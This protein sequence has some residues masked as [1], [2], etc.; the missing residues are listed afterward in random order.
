MTSRHSSCNQGRGGG[1]D[2]ARCSVPTDLV[3]MQAY[4]FDCPAEESLWHL[5]SAGASD[6]IA[7]HEAAALLTEDVGQIKDRV[8][9]LLP[10]T[11]HLMGAVPL[12]RNT[13]LNHR[14]LNHRRASRT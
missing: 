13:G 4:P 3:Q 11:S 6:R 7:R 14:A 1:Q 2:L 12:T 10:L 9:H 5:A 8:G